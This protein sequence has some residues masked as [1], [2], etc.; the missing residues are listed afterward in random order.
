[1]I[2]PY[3][4]KGSL[5]TSHIFVI[6]VVIL[7]TSTTLYASK[8]FIDNYKGDELITECAAVDMALLKYSESHIEVLPNSIR[9][10]KDKEGN[11]FIK[12]TKVRVY[13]ANLNELKNLQTEYG[14]IVKSID[15]DKFT[16]TTVRDSNG[17]MTYN[18]GVTLPNGKTYTSPNSN[19]KL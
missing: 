13:P 11:E 7:M 8:E 3:K 14:Y 16:Y 1:M 12:C 10:V 9:I 19:Q 18:L 5:I 6:L 15:L 2:M 17:Q 4:C